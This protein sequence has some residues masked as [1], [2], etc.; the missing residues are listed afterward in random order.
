MERYYGRPL[1]VRSPIRPRLTAGAI[2]AALFG[3]P[4][5]AGTLC[6]MLGISLFVAFG[7]ASVEQLFKWVS[8][9]LYGVYALFVVLSL[10]KFGDRISANFALDVPTDGWLLAGVTYAG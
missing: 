6:L 2:G 3:W 8:F 5:L 10:G 1:A 7:N 9:F 4:A